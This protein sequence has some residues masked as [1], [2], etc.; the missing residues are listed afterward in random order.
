MKK[1]LLPLLLSGALLA[2]CVQTF[3]EPDKSTEQGSGSRAPGSSSTPIVERDQVQKLSDALRSANFRVTT[4]AFGENPSTDGSVL[5][6]ISEDAILLPGTYN[7]GYIH[8][9][10]QGIFEYNLL[11]TT[12]GTVFD[13]EGMKLPVD[14]HVT[15]YLYTPVMLGG[16]A[17][18]IDYWPTTED[19]ESDAIIYDL[20]ADDEDIE[21]FLDAFE[22]EVP[23]GK[24]VEA[25]RVGFPR[26]GEIE[27]AIIG[28][29]LEDGT[30]AQGAFSDFGS[31]TNHFVEAVLND[32]TPFARDGWSLYDQMVLA[33]YEF[34]TIEYF[35]AYTLGFYP[36]FDLI[37]IGM[38][39]A[40]DYMMGQT[41]LYALDEEL[42]VERGYT[43]T[44]PLSADEDGEIYGAYQKTTT[45]A[46]YTV[47][48]DWFAAPEEQADLFPDGIVMVVYGIEPLYESTTLAEVNG[49]LSGAGLPTMP[50]DNVGVYVKHDT[51][52]AE[53]EQWSAKI[54]EKGYLEQVR[55]GD[56]IYYYGVNPVT[57]ED[58]YEP[59]TISSFPLKAYD[60]SLAV[61]VVFGTEEEAEALALS[62]ATKALADDDTFYLMDDDYET[63]EAQLADIGMLG[64]AGGTFGQYEIY[65][66]AEDGVLDL[67]ISA[68]TSRYAMFVKYGSYIGD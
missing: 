4:T 62:Y 32:P 50:E 6:V 11:S 39:G 48:I 52:D 1:T 51:T 63:P 20:D 26:E 16:F 46:V 55:N 66:A 44:T 8:K 23:E 5:E 61:R 58:S 30:F 19:Y 41:G 54:E 64:L 17:E 42:R 28:L 31:V 40:Y 18:A 68:M 65:M 60:L 22:F 14:A 37:G 47:E 59:I 15:D 45:M 38:V 21:M 43:A 57:G 67:I 3:S 25:V 34:D 24:T 33:D 29:F 2:S 56:W 27:G 53:N 10:G 9:E 36:I 35:D 13:L 49:L 12:E 7:Y